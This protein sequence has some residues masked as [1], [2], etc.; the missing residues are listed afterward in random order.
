MPYENIEA[1][2]TQ[3]DI[4]NIQDNIADIR[5]K[6]PFLVNLT[7]EERKQKGA[8]SKRRDI[9]VITCLEIAEKEFPTTLPAIDLT[10]WKKDV[11]LLE[12][13]MSIKRRMNILNEGLDDTIV[14]LKTETALTSNRFFGIL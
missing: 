13:L 5:A 4:Q 8:H 12:Q 1:E 14:A 6:L 7:K 3:V 2:L 10:G 9:Y 11:K